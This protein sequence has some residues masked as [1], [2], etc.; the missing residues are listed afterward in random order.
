MAFFKREKKDPTS[1]TQSETSSNTPSTN[2]DTDSISTTPST[3]Q[4]IWRQKF[5]NRFTSKKKGKK[6]QLITDNGVKSINTSNDQPISE[7]DS[8]KNTTEIQNEV[9]NDIITNQEGNE[10]ADKSE[11]NVNPSSDID[12]TTPSPTTASTSAST[13]IEE[14]TKPKNDTQQELITNKPFLS[15]PPVV[16]PTPK[17]KKANDTWWNNREGYTQGFLISLACLTVA[18]AITMPLLVLKTDLFKGNNLIVSLVTACTATI[19]IAVGMIIGECCKDNKKL[20][21]AQVEGIKEQNIE[22]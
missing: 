14:N 5:K 9:N 15:S 6:D 1:A 18:L 20:D 22:V 13:V 11:K 2:G 17:S 4:S 10:N 12:K 3:K 7:A 16:T 21:E 19:I 8:P